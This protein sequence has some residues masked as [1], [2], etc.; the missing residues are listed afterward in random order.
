MA[1]REASNGRS[2]IGTTIGKMNEISASTLKRTAARFLAD[3]HAA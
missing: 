2:R 1:T 3:V